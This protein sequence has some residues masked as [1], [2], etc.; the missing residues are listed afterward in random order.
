MVCMVTLDYNLHYHCGMYRMYIET[1][2]S[3]T[4]L[5]NQIR[6]KRK[7]IC[8]DWY[9][10]YILIRNAVRTTIRPLPLQNCVWRLQS[11]LAIPSSELLL[12]LNFCARSCQTD[13]NATHSGHLQ[14]NCMIMNS[15]DISQQDIYFYWHIYWRYYFLLLLTSVRRTTQ[16]DAW[17]QFFRQ[18]CFPSNWLYLSNCLV[19]DYIHPV[20]LPQMMWEKI[21][22]EEKSLQS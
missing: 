2:L 3:G 19:V 20:L 21:L 10:Y 12:L 9:Y 15:K 11:A 18:N 5:Y 7:A 8:W 14:Q 17:L 16:R 1:H 4:E 22:Q 6:K 13:D